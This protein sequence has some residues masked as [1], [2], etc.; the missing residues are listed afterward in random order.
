MSE[1]AR[2]VIVTGGTG[3]LGAAV[4]RAFLGEG[5]RVV[6]P[7]IVAGER[8]RVAAAEADALSAGR[9]VL[10]E[11]DVADEA[12]AAS[13]VRAAGEP[14]VLVNGVGGFA[15]GA[16]HEAPLADLDRLWRMNVRSLVAMSRAVLPGMMARRSGVILNVASRAAFERPGGISAYVAAKA[17][18]V[19]L[20]ETMQKEVAAT[21]I[22]VNAI[23]PT[24]I[25]TPANR[26]AMPDADSSLWTP[27][28]RIAAVLR[29]LASDD[30]ATVRGGL[31]PV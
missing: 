17:A 2:C 23:V 11:A 29:F 18:V 24:T 27:P 4:V 26:A 15:A 30:G 8:E 13:V 25:D 12:G 10:L 20:T 1:P 3:A 5:A 9:L 19:A 16:V 28:A 22:R 7:W 6:V 14:A 21:G 31:V